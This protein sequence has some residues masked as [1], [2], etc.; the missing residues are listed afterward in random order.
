MIPS[1]RSVASRTVVWP[2]AV[3][4]AVALLAAF[5]LRTQAQ[6]E[7]TLDFRPIGKNKT[8]LALGQRYLQHEID[9]GYDLYE[10]LFKGKS[11]VQI[12]RE[13]TSYIRV[14][15]NRDGV[16]EIFLQLGLMSHCGTAGCETVLLRRQNGSWQELDNLQTNQI[17]LL[18]EWDGPYRRVEYQRGYITQD[19]PTRLILRWDG[20]HPWTEERDMDGN[21]V[22]EYGRYPW[23]QPK[24]Q[25]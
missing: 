6:K 17:I 22:E 23:P 18:N 10:H 5:V 1:M 12:I 13:N 14:D 11:D 15:L 9:N 4:V 24:S 2:V 3:L 21:T 19:F 20:D 25:E 8:L 16:P 7:E